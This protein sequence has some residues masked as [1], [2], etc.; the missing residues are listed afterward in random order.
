MV[1]LISDRNAYDTGV[2]IS[3]DPLYGSDRHR[4]VQ[5]IEEGDTR[6]G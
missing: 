5:S 2:R 1:L 6:H 3:P 4:S